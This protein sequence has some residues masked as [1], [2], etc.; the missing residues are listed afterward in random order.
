MENAPVGS[1]SGTG[2]VPETT[3]NSFIDKISSR[4]GLLSKLTINS[5]WF[6]NVNYNFTGLYSNIICSLSKALL[7]SVKFGR[8]SEYFTLAI[9]CSNQ[10]PIST[11]ITRQILNLFVV[12]EKWSNHNII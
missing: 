10:I 7:H 11:E 6:R 4:Y 8:W 9:V 1:G 3:F 5:R 2:V 12:I